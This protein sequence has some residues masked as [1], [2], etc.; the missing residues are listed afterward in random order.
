MNYDI[1]NLLGSPP[2]TGLHLHINDYK[3]LQWQG[4]SANHVFISCL[5]LTLLVRFSVE[6]SVGGTL[7]SNAIEH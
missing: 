2:G 7:F 4:S 3:D 6:F 5:H 1:V